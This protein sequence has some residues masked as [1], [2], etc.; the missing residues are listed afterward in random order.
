MDIGF[1]DNGGNERPD[2]LVIE[3][4]QD[5]EIQAVCVLLFDS[6]DREHQIWFEESAEGYEFYEHKAPTN[7]ISQED[8][9]IYE[10]IRD[11]HVDLWIIESTSLMRS[12]KL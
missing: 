11:K 6:D 9:A 3:K 1:R 12:V 5:D 2:R 7:Q 8:M 10:D 4:Y